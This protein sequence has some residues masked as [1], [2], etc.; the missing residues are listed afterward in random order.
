MVIYEDMQDLEIEQW[1]L[2]LLRS[3]RGVYNIEIHEMSSRSLFALKSLEIQGSRL[4]E[5][6]LILART[7]HPTFLT[8]RRRRHDYDTTTRGNEI[9]MRLECG[10][11]V[12]DDCDEEAANGMERGNTPL[13][14]VR[15]RLRCLG[16]DEG[17]G[18]E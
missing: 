12:R 11:K 18:K 5:R 7:R 3:I 8:S 2:S 14:G 4:S 9:V 17:E 16:H 13:V 6:T 10:L 1:I 15:D